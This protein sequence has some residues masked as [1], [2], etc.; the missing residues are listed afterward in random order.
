MS[1]DKNMRIGDKRV[2]VDHDEN[3][4][5]GD[6]RVDVDHDENMRIGDKRVDVDHDETIVKMRFTRV[7]RGVYYQNET[8]CLLGR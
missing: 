6:K 2:D 8:Y 1:A 5:I 4:R 3:M 7:H